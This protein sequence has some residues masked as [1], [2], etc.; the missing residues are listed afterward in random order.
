M[1]A[2]FRSW[3]QVRNCWKNPGL[4]HSV[5]NIGTKSWRAMGTELLRTMGAAKHR[6]GKQWRRRNAMSKWAMGLVP[7]HGDWY[8]TT[9]PDTLIYSVSS[10]TERPWEPIPWFTL[11]K[12]WSL[13]P[14]LAWLGSIFA[15]KNHC[16][17]TPWSFIYQQFFHYLYHRQ[18]RQMIAQKKVISTTFC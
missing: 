10:E 15:K 12:P 14:W 6:D 8:R 4:C 9:V 17:L 3:K 5:R 16:T 7:S 1:R 2:E 13:Y 11:L 18:Y